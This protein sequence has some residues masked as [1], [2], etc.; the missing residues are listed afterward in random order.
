MLRDIDQLWVFGGSAHAIAALAAKLLSVG[1]PSFILKG[2]P[3]PI[4]FDLHH[5]T[6]REFVKDR[7]QPLRRGA[8]GQLTRVAEV[9]TPKALMNSTQ[10]AEPEGIE[11]SGPSS[12][13]LRKSAWYHGT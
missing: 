3:M 7:R 5:L 1:H 2:K 11:Y 12:S 9:G 10:S 8:S 13:I 6:R 4:E